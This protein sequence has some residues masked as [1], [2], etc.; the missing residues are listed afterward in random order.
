MSLND[1]GQFKNNNDQTQ[2][3]TDGTLGKCN[4]Y[5]HRNTCHTTKNY[6]SRNCGTPKPTPQ[7]IVEP[8]PAL[9]PRPI[10]IQFP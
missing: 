8:I 7:P 6:S 2:N 9:T 3:T 4:I 5:C 10:T 1:L